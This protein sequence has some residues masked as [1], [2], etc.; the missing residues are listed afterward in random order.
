MANAELFR[1]HFAIDCRTGTEVVGVNAD[2]KTVGVRD[3]ATGAVS[4]ERKRRAMPDPARL[5]RQRDLGW[6]AVA[7]HSHHVIAAAVSREGGRTRFGTQTAGRPGS[8]A[9]RKR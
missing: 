3:V 7:R 4:T 8:G 5:Q 9:D 1:A 2:A 6:H